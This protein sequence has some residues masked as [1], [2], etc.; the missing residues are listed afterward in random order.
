[1]HHKTRTSLCNGV[2]LAMLAMFVVGLFALVW[3]GLPSPRLPGEHQTVAVAHGS[4]PPVTYTIRQSETRNAQM[5]QAAFDRIGFDLD[6]VSQGYISVPR[7]LLASLPPD[8][9]RLD[10]MDARRVLFL[11]TL[12]PVILHIND[13][14]GVDRQKLLM[15]KAAM[16]RGET[17]SATDVQWI[18]ALA[19]NYDQP[20]AD[21]DVLL[22]K[23]DVIPP[24]L[25]LAQAIEESGWGTSRIAREQNAIFGQFGQGASGDWDYRNFASLTEAVASYAHNLNTHRA[26]R[27]FRQMRAR[28][29]ATRGGIDSLELSAT[30]HRYS[31]RGDDYVT[32]LRAIIRGNALEDFDAARLNLRSVATILASN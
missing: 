3:S 18:L 11:R 1:M 21:V 14:I 32:T 25:A 27:E 30:L 20:D 15:I 13:Q 31:E 10:A 12:L 5:L 17:L 28:M 16:T 24:S 2:L 23:V 29:R 22:K 6:A 19:D 4:L 7:V 9:D 26:Y 8:L